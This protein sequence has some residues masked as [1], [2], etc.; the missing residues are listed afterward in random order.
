MLLH[1]FPQTIGNRNRVAPRL[2]LVTKSSEVKGMDTP[3]IL[4]ID[5]DKLVRWSV[6]MVLGRAGYL[7]QEAASGGEGLAALRSNPPDLVLLDITLPDMDGFS[8]LKTIRQSHPN[9]PVLMMTADA[10]S[11]TTREAVRLGARGH[12]DKPCDPDLLQTAVSDALQSAK[13]QSQKGR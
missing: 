6:S 7:I 9:L 8:V 13:P 1:L 10:T 2:L 12:L 3:K 4:V 11:E 5:D